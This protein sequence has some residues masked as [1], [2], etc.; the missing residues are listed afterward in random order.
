MKKGIDTAI[1]KTFIGLRKFLR[2]FAVSPALFVGRVRPARSISGPHLSTV[3][4][5]VPLW[6]LLL[7]LP[8][9][10]SPSLQAVQMKPLSIEQL[11][12]KSVLV[13]RGVV[14]SKSCQRDSAGRIY[15]RVAL[16]VTDVWKGSLA[17]H[18]FTIVH[19]GGIL[20]AEKAAVSGQAE[21][22]IGEDVVTFLVLNHRGE[23]VTVGLAQGKFH[24]WQEP[25]TGEQFVHDLFQAKPDSRGQAVPANALLPAQPRLT[26]A[27]L[28]RRV[29]GGQP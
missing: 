11:A 26:L 9:A 6:V 1:R 7:L 18:Q 14:L 12:Q 15:T 17:T 4:A 3:V 28:K 2:K 29:R 5:A 23:G 20:G 21:Y 27:E 8:D 25:E 10:A 24:V 13:V 19:G 16:Q 22:R